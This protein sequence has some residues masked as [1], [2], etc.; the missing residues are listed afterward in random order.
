MNNRLADDD[1]MDKL[2]EYFS[3]MPTNDF[4]DVED[5]HKKQVLEK[6]KKALIEED[7]EEFDR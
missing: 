6:F 1:K 5:S 3:K 4:P 7:V 2:N